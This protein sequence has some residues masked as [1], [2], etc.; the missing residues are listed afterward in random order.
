[1][2]AYQQFRLLQQINQLTLL[3]DDGERPLTAE[4]RSTLYH[5]AAEDFSR[6]DKRKRLLTWSAAKKI[7]KPFGGNPKASF[8]LESEQRKGLD[9]DSTSAWLSDETCLEN[10]GFLLKRKNKMKLS[11][12]L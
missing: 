5:Y 4:E 2:P 1:M 3:Y 8:N 6:L 12:C 7:L 11:S 9:A 10:G